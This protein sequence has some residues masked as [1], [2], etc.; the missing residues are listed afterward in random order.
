[1]SPNIKKI[2]TG[3]AVFLA[4]ILLLYWLFAETLLYSDNLIESVFFRNT[5][6]KGIIYAKKSII[7]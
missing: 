7:S 4:I 3:I 5:I 2:G 6:F 1:M